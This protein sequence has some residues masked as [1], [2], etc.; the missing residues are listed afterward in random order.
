[1]AVIS[2]YI[3]LPYFFR[4]FCNQNTLKLLYNKTNDMQFLEF[5]SDNI[6][7]KFKKVYL[8]GF[9]IQFITMHGQYNI[10]TLKLNFENLIDRT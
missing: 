10:K 3:Q 1:M 7:I 5:Y 9:I 2:K 4:T 8:V 6:R